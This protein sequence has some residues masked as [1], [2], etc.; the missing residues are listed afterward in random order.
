MTDQDIE[1]FEA[2]FKE[3][4]GKIRDRDGLE[5]YSYM[6]HNSMF[7]GFEMGIKYK[8]QEIEILKAELKDARRLLM[9]E[10]GFK[11]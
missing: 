2:Q 10:S 6:Q 1:Y 5:S 7:I 11:L 3:K 4:P 8:Q 9:K